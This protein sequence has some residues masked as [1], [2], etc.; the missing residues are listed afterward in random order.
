MPLIPPLIPPILPPSK[1]G[2]KVG[3]KAGDDLARDETVRLSELLRRNGWGAADSRNNKIARGVIKCES[4]F[5]PDR[6]NTD[7]TCAPGERAVGLMQVCTVHRGTKGIP[8]DHDKAIT[9]LKDPDNNVKVGR[10]VLREQGWSA[11][12]CAKT[13]T[14]DDPEIT[15][16]K[17]IQDT[18]ADITD[19]LLS[20]LD[21]ISGFF[22]ILTQADTWLRVGKVWLGGVLIIGGSIALI[23]AGG[24][25]AANSK[26]GRIATSVAPSPVKA[27]TKAV[28]K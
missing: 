17:T 21:A 16:T 20:P 27:V 25:V 22:G 12:T 3:N 28:A 1:A 13:P 4:T 7:A 23:F 8:R 26:P 2:A 10:A 14:N 11:W 5:D 6:I 15:V 19:T 9:Y 18:A 24:K